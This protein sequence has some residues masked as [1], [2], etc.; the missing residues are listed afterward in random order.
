MG[1]RRGCS[2]GLRCEL[3]HGTDSNCVPNTAGEEPGKSGEYVRGE[4]FSSGVE[5]PEL[6]HTAGAFQEVTLTVRS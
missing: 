4:D 6:P 1:C 3:G 2:S 5:V